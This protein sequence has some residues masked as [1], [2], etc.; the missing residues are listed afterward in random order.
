M[1]VK[2]LFPDARL[3]ERAYDSAGYDLF[4]LCAKEIDSGNFARCPIGIAV[5]IPPGHVG[6]IK[7]RSSLEVDNLN[8][9][10]GVIDED[11]RGEVIVC[12]Q[13]THPRLVKRIHAGEKIAQLLVVPVYTGDVIEVDEL[14]ETER[15][16]RGFG[17]SGA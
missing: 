11:Y 8:V 6:I 17:S 14:S 15:G 16:A 1:K 7:S 3:P 2:K 10:A 13:N 9:V 5:E 12:L 4:Y